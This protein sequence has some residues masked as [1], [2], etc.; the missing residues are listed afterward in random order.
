MPPSSP[1]VTALLADLSAGNDAVVNALMPLIYDELHRL[2]RR[3]RRR[4]AQFTL[5]TTALVHEAYLN[6][7]QQDRV[8]WKN[9]AH[10]MAVAATV[11]R[12]LLINYARHR[13][14]Q[15]RGGDQ[16]LATFEEHLIPHTTRSEEL[17]ALD[18][19]LERLAALNERQAK[20]VECRFF[21]GLTQEETAEVL[22]VSV[23]TVR[24]DWRLARAWLGRELGF[25]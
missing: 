14:T 19:A 5:N 20:V 6:L 25:V 3:Q 7:V 11:M 4:E 10:F 13:S 21:A 17:L 18:E 8:D 24:R 1:N 2:A 22:G 23:P 16:V 12:R 9:R 15:K